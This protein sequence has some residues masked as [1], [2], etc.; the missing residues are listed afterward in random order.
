MT[1]HME[2]VKRF[3]K[4]IQ[5]LKSALLPPTQCVFSLREFMVVRRTPLPPD[6]E[7]KAVIYLS[8]S[9]SEITGSKLKEA[10]YF[11]GRQSMLHLLGG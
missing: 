6:Y 1:L 4:R 2:L 5:L 7:D 8:D 9:S 3:P 10:T 11:Y